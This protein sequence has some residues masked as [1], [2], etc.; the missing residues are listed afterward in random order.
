MEA[1]QDIETDGT[2]NSIHDRGTVTDD[3]GTVTDYEAR[4]RDVRQKMEYLRAIRR[5]TQLQTQKPTSAD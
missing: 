2:Q 1:R 3:K 4:S 5:A